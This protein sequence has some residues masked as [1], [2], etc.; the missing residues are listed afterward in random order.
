MCIFRWIRLSLLPVAHRIRCGMRAHTLTH[1]HIHSRTKHRHLARNPFICDCN[2]RW[3]ADYLHKN[4][5]E[6]SGARC[7]APKRMHRRRI[8]ALRDEKFKCKFH[9]LQFI[10]SLYRY[11]Y[12][13]IEM[14]MMHCTLTR[15]PRDAGAFIFIMNFVFGSVSRGSRALTFRGQ[16]TKPRSERRLHENWKQL[17]CVACSTA[18]KKQFFGNLCRKCTRNMAKIAPSL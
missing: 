1:A 4:P 17:H 2:L 3:L 12:T 5:I 6:T 16:D 18:I 8:E 11:L 14:A 15:L 9:S 7:D 13:C 10:Q